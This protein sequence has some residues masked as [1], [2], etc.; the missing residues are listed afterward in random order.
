MISLLMSLYKSL[1]ASLITKPIVKN[2]MQ[3]AY[4]KVNLNV[5]HR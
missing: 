4:K 2:K 5:A 3:Y 1:T